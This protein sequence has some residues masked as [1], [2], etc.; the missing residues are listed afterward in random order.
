MK[1]DPKLCGAV[2]VALA[3]AGP[4]GYAAGQI[5]QSHMQNA[6]A[7]LQTARGELEA[8]A[9]NKGGHRAR[10]EF[11]VDQAIAQVRA[12]ME[13]REEEGPRC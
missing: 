9:R 6:L 1:A 7:A 10:A 3:L 11:Y 13:A 4:A 12:G 5:R 8:A 2:V